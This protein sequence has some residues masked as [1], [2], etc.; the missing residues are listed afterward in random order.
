MQIRFGMDYKASKSNA[1]RAGYY[2]DP[3]P[4]PDETVNILFPSITNNVITF[5]LG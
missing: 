4:D 2:N 3:A 1:L 5:G